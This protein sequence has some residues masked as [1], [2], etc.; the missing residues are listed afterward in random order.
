MHTYQSKGY[1]V[2]KVFNAILMTLI[3][4]AI[5]YPIYYMV[6]VSLSDGAYV[7]SGRVTWRPMGS[8][9]RA[10]RAILR[11]ELFINS[12]KNTLI[13]T[14]LGTLINLL[15]TMLCAYPLSRKELPG[16]RAMMTFATFTMFFTGGMIPNYLLVT[17]LGLGGTYWAVI[18]P[19]AISVYNMIIMRTFFEGIPVSLTEAAYIDGASD[20]RVLFNIVLPLS[21]PIIMTMILFYAVGHWNGYFNAMLYL[22]DKEMYPIQLFVRSIVLAGETLSASM[23]SNVDASAE[24][25]AT[26]LAEQSTKY[27]VVI[28]AMLPILIIY[29]IISKYFKGG[30]MIGAVKG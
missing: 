21:K 12:Y 16:R 15:M 27:A 7:L 11:D 4:L 13:I 24:Y 10:Y 3:C 17:S 1:K 25:G 30:V 28:L 18:L 23:A 19:G 6:I 5:L 9:F 26:L 20:M 22:N 2:F 29:P 8:T 14:G